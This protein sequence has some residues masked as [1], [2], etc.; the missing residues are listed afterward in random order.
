MLEAYAY[1]NSGNFVEK[2]EGSK[3]S[4]LFQQ[5]QS[6]FGHCLGKIVENNIIKGWRFAQ[7]SGQE[8]CSRVAIINIILEK[9]LWRETEKSS[10]DWKTKPKKSSVM[11]KPNKRSIINKKK[12]VIDK[13]CVLA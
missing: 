10:T 3:V 9:G 8:V 5:S 2:L 11:N 12:E 1:D 4:V 7:C 6:Y 13:D